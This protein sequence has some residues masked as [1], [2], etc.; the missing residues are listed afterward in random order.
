MAI[1]GLPGLPAT[2]SAGFGMLGL[3]N[4]PP[5]PAAAKVFANWLASKEGLELWARARKESPTRNDI[6]EA[7]FLLPNVIP[8]PNE[9]YLD[10]YGW[11]FTVNTREKVRQHM[12]TLLNR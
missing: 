9:E 10:T 4:Q 6:D 12:K 11:E 7:S 3:F 8:K 2:V 1:Y 5:H